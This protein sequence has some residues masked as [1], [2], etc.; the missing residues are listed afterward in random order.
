ADHRAGH[1][2]ALAR[3]GREAR[4]GDVAGEADLHPNGAQTRGERALE[5]SSTA[6]RV[7]YDHDAVAR[8]SEHMTRRATEAEGELRRQVFVRDPADA[9]G[10]KEASHLGRIVTV[11]LAGCTVCT[12]TPDGTRTATS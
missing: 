6:P 5:H 1:E 10:A 4:C 9:V 11:T 7:A 3:E 2:V 12:F 8:P